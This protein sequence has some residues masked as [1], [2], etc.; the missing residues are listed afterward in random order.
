MDNIRAT[1]QAKSKKN[2]LIRAWQ[3][4]KTGKRDG[5]QDE[6]SLG[7]I[8]IAVMGPTGAGKSSFINAVTGRAEAVVG[9]SLESCTKDLQEF[10]M[11][12]P[13]ELANKYPRLSSLNIVLVDTP[14]FDNSDL[15]DSEILQRMALWLKNRRAQGVTISGII[16][17]QESTRTT[18]KVLKQ[19]LNI[20]YRRFILVTT[21]DE[22]L[23]PE[24]GSQ[25]QTRSKL[26]KEFVENGAA[27]FPATAHSK[28]L[29]YIVSLA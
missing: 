1:D 10:K 29:E 22:V 3:Y 8:F 2:V 6:S 20:D 5:K 12:M 27:I 17:M 24:E 19:L 9:H 16:Y 13:L 11:P 4:L 23:L 15:D 26:W 14:G 18:L 28:I 25:E 7:D 21:S